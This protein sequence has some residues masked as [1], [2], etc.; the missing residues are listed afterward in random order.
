LI[1]KVRGTIAVPAIGGDEAR[2]HSWLLLI[3]L[4]PGGP[5]KLGR[6]VGA[7]VSIGAADVNARKERAKAIMTEGIM[8]YEKR[9]VEFIRWMRRRCWENGMNNE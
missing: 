2:L 5:P 8:R 7:R 9:E 3:M 1:S 6:Q 4:K